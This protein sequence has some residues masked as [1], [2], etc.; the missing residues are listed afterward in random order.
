MIKFNRIANKLGLAGLFGILLA[1]GM[2]VNQWVSESAVK[3]ANQRA[4]AQERIANHALQAHVG[5]RKMQLS[6]RDIRLATTPDVVQAGVKN[7]DEAFATMKKQAGPR[8]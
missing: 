4:D 1:G 7:L 8:F 5:L 6:V 2:L 3:Q